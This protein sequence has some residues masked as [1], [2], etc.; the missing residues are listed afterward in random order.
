M[1][2]MQ[3]LYN[4][5]LFS[6]SCF[7]SKENRYRSPI[8]NAERLIG[9]CFAIALLILSFILIKG[10][11][12]ILLG[13]EFWPIVDLF[14]IAFALFISFKLMDVQEAY[15]EKKGG[16]KRYLQYL[17]ELGYRCSYGRIIATITFFILTLMIT[18]FIFF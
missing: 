16:E 3:R 6:F 12:Y 5:L 15:I 11:A 18:F 4:E 8:D 17:H 10:G 9:I 1:N 7:F 13:I 2:V 14:I